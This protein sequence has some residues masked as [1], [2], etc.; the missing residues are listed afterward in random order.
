[1]GIG[2]TSIANYEK[3]IRFPSEDKLINLANTLDTSVDSLL[4]RTPTLELSFSV[5]NKHLSDKFIQFIMN[6][7]EEEA[8]D[9][10]LSLVRQG[11]DPLDI[12]EEFLKPTLYKVGDMWEKGE[13]SVAFEHHITAIVDNLIA[14]LSPHINKHDFWDKKALFMTVG[15]EPHIIGL[16]MVR[17]IFRFFGWK[18]YFLGSNVPWQSAINIINA[19]E[20]DWVC[21]SITSEKNLNS[22]EAFVQQLREKCNV[23]V[24]VGGQAIRGSKK[25]FG[26]LKGRLLYRIRIRFKRF[27]K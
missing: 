24:M 3:N 25:D 20:I 22:A 14:M 12:H 18:T 15:N 9:M 4:G 10:A 26:S 19:R 1:M 17:E 13:V 7:S 2:Q 11:Y 6:G 16:K 8:I 27:T 23:K 21:I 5:E